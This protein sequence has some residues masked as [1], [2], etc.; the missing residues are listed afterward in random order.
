MDKKDR[1]CSNC[2]FQIANYC[3]NLLYLASIGSDD[4]YV[5]VEPDFHCEFW[6]KYPYPNEDDLSGE[7]P[8]YMNPSS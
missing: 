2:K 5:E 1:K 3:G 4:T 6:T 8:K 7:R